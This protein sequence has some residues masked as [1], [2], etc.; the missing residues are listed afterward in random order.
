MDGKIKAEQLDKFWLV[1]ESEQGGQIVGIVFGGINGWKLAITKSV[2]INAACDSGNFCNP[3]GVQ[4][5]LEKMNSRLKI[6]I[7]T[8]PCNLQTRVPNNPFWK[9]HPDM[10]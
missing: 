1:A 8:D 6:W 9:C 3:K 4:Q 7:L 5:L 2:A 10:L